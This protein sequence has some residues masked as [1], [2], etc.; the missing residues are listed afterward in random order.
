MIEQPTGGLEEPKPREQVGGNQVA[1]SGLVFKLRKPTNKFFLMHEKY[2]ETDRAD[3]KAI[4]KAF[5]KVWGI[6]YENMKLK[7]GGAS[8]MTDDS[9]YQGNATLTEYVPTWIYLRW[10]DVYHKIEY[11]ES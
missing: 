1:T 6:S 4:A 8:F 10:A 2:R 3:L 5:A 11:Y 9:D 7:A